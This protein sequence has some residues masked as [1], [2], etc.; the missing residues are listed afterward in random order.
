MP[1]GAGL[2]VIRHGSRTGEAARVPPLRL[3]RVPWWTTDRFGKGVLVLVNVHEDDEKMGAAR[4]RN[5]LDSQ[6][7]ALMRAG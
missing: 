2:R 3:N 7:A 1:Q 5:S 6:M 4:G